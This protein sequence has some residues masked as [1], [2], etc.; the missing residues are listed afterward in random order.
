MGYG[1]ISGPYL[2]LRAWG[3]RR[4]WQ[5]FT[6]PKLS[7]GVKGTICVTTASHGTLKT[8]AKIQNHYKQNFMNEWL[9]L[10]WDYLLFAKTLRILMMVYT[11]TQHR[12]GEKVFW[13]IFISHLN[14]QQ[15]ANPDRIDPIRKRVKIRRNLHWNWYRYHTSSKVNQQRANED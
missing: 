4:N 2:I 11:Y 12:W 14:F 13:E 6:G 10:V 7:A 15:R 8:L 9:C 3:Q 1:K 5:K